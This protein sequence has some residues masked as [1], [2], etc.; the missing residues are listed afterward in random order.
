[1]ALNLYNIQKWYKM[2]VGKSELHVNQ[3]I[4]KCFVP[5]EIKG[6]FNNMTE[7]VLTAPELLCN[8]DLPKIVTENGE[9]IFFPVAIFQYGL[10]AYDLYLQTHN[11][12]YLQ[13]FRQCVDWCID[14]Q[15]ESGAWNN[16]FF[17]YPTHPYGAMCQGEGV[18]LLVRAY[19]EFGDKI[20]YEAA[21]KA[22][23]FLL[24][25]IGEGGT[26]LYEGDNVYLYEYTHRGVVLNGWIF[27][28]FGLYDFI[29]IHKDREIQSVFEKTIDTLKHDLKRFDNGYWSMYDLED[30]IASPFYHNL[31]IAQMQALYL[32]TGDEIF[33]E[34]TDKWINYQKSKRGKIKSFVVKSIQKIK[35]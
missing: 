15:E 21:N 32:V 19:K 30:R 35:E 11:Q 28:I 16:F 26:T 31:H 3:D 9:K 18:S 12:K 29:L 33:K 24:T 34:Y 10:G 2:I 23:N 20:Y 13:K 4:G 5:G 14:S 7:K 6:Y 17:Y 8:S 27:A 22:I 1:M 25:P